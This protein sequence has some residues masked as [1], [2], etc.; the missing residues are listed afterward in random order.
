MGGELSEEE[1][2]ENICGKII[3]LT[4]PGAERKLPFL[5]WRSKGHRGSHRTYYYWANE[6]DP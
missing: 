2:P 6:D 3:F 4:E 5:C 1:I